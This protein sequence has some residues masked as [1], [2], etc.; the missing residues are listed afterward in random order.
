VI[1]I[2]TSVAVKWFVPEAGTA[3]ALNL[4]SRSLVA[5][6]LLQAELGHALTR[7]VRRGELLEDQARSAFA[8]A[9]GLLSLLPSRPHAE[10]AFD[11]SLDLGH[12]TGDCYF[13]ALAATEN[14]LLV[15]ADTK[16]VNKLATTSYASLV[17]SLG[18]ALP[19][20]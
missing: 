19:R 13:L 1:V 3:D 7:K 2:D 5:P 4:L 18:D 12:A 8:N 9:P 17:F 14:L 20:G 11:L 16:F 15:T 10:L 6:D